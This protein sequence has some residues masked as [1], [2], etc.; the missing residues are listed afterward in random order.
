MQLNNKTIWLDTLTK[1]KLSI[2]KS[3]YKTWFKETFLQEINSVGVA[4]IAVPNQ[5]TKNWMNEK[6]NQLITKNLIEVEP[7]IKKVEYI[8]KKNSDSELKSVNYKKSKSISRNQESTPRKNLSLRTEQ[9][10]LSTN[11]NKKYTFDNFVIGSFN[12]VAYAAAQAVVRRLDEVVYNPFVVYGNTG[13]GKTHLIQAIGNYIRKNYPEKKVFY[14]TSEKFQID[15]IE[16]IGMK[17]GKNLSFKKKYRKY[18]VL[19]LDDIQFFTKKE[20][21]QEEI[22]HVFNYL[23]DNNKQIILSSDRH[24]N[25][26][27]DLE[28]RLRSRFNAGM[29]VDIQK[30]DFESRVEILKKKLKNNSYNINEKTLEYIASTITG[31]IRELEGVLNNIF[32]QTELKGAQIP[33]EDIKKIIKSTFKKKQPLNDVKLVSLVAN[34]YN[35]NDDQIYKKSRKKEFV[36]PRQVVMYL[37]REDFGYS[38]PT[39]GEKIGGRD[40]TTVM[41]SYSKIEKELKD[42]VNLQNT[43]ENL[44]NMY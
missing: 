6:F 24:P 33:L 20:R 28:D 4:L 12:E 10:N 15:V 19:I 3:N 2:S 44:R 35:I 31:N 29:T 32:I 7:S 38:Y 42:D 13:Y 9:T 36:K 34:Y 25:Q 26:I 5:F 37:L 8:V 41:H 23:Y 17:S 22:F 39:I 1:I 14:T 43:I 21:T 16:F 40:H 27:P 11:L 18:D 30:P